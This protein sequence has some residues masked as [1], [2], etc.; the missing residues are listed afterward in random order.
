MVCF[1]G[2]P[3]LGEGLLLEVHSQI[4]VDT[5]EQILNPWDVERKSCRR[6]RCCMSV[7]PQFKKRNEVEGEVAALEEDVNW[8]LDKEVVDLFF[9]SP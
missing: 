1:F 7:I 4:Y 6:F 8:K 9:E 3:L 5:D 2:E